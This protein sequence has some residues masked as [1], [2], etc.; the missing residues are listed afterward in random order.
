M[1]PAREFGIMLYVRTRDQ[2]TIN[3]SKIESF[4]YVDAKTEVAL[5]HPFVSVYYSNIKKDPTPNRI[6]VLLLLLLT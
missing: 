6:P 4:F 3:A 1:V 2:T 5:T